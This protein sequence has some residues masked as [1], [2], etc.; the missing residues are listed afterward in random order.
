MTQ[1]LIAD[2]DLPAYTI[3]NQ[4]G[5]S[6]CILTCE[7]A[8]VAVPASLNKLGLDDED[9]TRHYAVDVGMARV[10]ETLSNLLDAPAIL[11]NYSRLV[12]DLNRDVN[13]PTAF[14]VQGEGKPIPGNINMSAEDRAARIHEI[15]DPYE[16]MLESMLNRAEESG[17][18]PVVLSLHSFTRQFYNYT[19]PW[20]VGFLWTHDSRL[21]YAMMPYF[22]GLGM[23]VGDNQPYDHRILRGSSINRHADTRR[24][25]NTLVEIRNDL[26]LND[27]SADEWAGWI[28]D[29]LQ[30]G[31]ANPDVCAYYDGPLTEYDPVRERTYYEE[32]IEKSKRGECYG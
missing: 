22:K 25:S 15:Y 12:V 29:S 16:G 3:L 9:Y 4:N 14:A 1:R 17:Q 23:E 18:P 11:G 2:G 30:E 7:H 13:H 26:I 10:T 19:R 24:L 8:G 21:S 20:Q 27:K 28:A 5:R 6:R 32:L 31:L